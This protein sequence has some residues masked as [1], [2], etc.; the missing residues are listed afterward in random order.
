MKTEYR[1]V[2]AFALFLLLTCIV[3]IAR[4]GTITWTWTNPAQYE[5]GSALSPADI[6]QTRIEFGSCS[7]TAFGTKQG[8]VVNAGNGTTASKASL[9]P[10]I[11]CSRAFTTAKGQESLASNVMVNTIAQP[12]P[13]PPVLSAIS[14]LAMTVKKTSHGWDLVDNVGIVRL[15]SECNAEQSFGNGY[16]ALKNHRTDVV[17]YAGQKPR[18]RIAVLCG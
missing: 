11:Y 17:Y 7:G 13:K 9:I 2:G 3:G 1:I 15:G 18:T 5:D 6:S 12:N 14:S 4:A 16:F 10:G 8:E